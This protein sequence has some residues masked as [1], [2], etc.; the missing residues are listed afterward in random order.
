MAIVDDHDS[1]R[2]SLARAMRLEGIRVETF[3]SA[4]AYLAYSSPTPPRCLVLDMHLP[5]MSG[6]D[7]SHFLHRERPPLPP[8]VFITAHDDLLASL[9]GCCTP[10]GRLAKPFEID[11]LL[12]LVWPLF[13]EQA[14][15]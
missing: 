1:M 4:E 3:A 8:T 10:Y 15:G 7:L 9:D 6:H 14:A 2:S 11:A 13:R 12:S 5:G